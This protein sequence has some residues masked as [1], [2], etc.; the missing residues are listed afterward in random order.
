MFF[1]TS[2]FCSALD[3]ILSFAFNPARLPFTTMHWSTSVPLLC[4]SM[5]TFITGSLALGRTD[6][7]YAIMDNDWYTVGFVPYLVA[8][9]G[10]VEILGLASGRY[11]QYTYRR[12]LFTNRNFRYC[13]QLAATGSIARS[14][15][16]RGRESQ[17]YSSL[18]G[19]HMAADQHPAALP[20]MGDDP[21]QTTL[22][23][24]FRS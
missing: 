1:S 7:H 21:W 10:D 9:D 8:L 5:L 11:L 22:A 14:S 20:C 17:L 3:V 13:Q 19:C 24:R 4:S 12:G 6:K 15:N 23:R 18:P 2:Q 16:P